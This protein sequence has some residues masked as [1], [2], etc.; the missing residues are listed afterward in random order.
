M[1]R[2]GAEGLARYRSCGAEGGYGPDGLVPRSAS[3][4]EWLSGAVDTERVEAAG[5]RHRAQEAAYELRARDLAEP[6]ALAGPFLSDRQAALRLVESLIAL[7]TLS[8]RDLLDLAAAPPSPVAATR[9][10]ALARLAPVPKRARPRRVGRATGA[11]L[12]TGSAG[13]AEP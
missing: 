4:L 12:R 9:A 10:P 3:V 2:W 11:S 1:S 6:E 7:G 13:R 5:W 8:P